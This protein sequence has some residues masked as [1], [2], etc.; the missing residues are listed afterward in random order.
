MVRAMEVFL[1][2]FVIFSIS[3]NYISWASTMFPR[4]QEYGEQ[5]LF[6]PASGQKGP[7]ENVW[8]VQ[9]TS[10][11]DLGAVAPS[12]RRDSTVGGGAV[13]GLVP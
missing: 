12:K 1:L 6:L 7:E 9:R 4:H 5:S 10:F 3:F 13:G 2:L 8:A 11:E